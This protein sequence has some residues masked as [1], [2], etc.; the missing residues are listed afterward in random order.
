MHQHQCDRLRLGI[1]FQVVLCRVPRSSRVDAYGDAAANE[2]LRRACDTKP[3]VLQGVPCY[4]HN[5]TL[6]W[7]NDAPAPCELHA[8]LLLNQTSPGQAAFSSRRPAMPRL[9]GT[10]SPPQGILQTTNVLT[11][12]Q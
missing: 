1:L 8:Q 5:P 12:Y 6:T 3:T 10:I 4:G 11:Q 7:G 9:A 2:L